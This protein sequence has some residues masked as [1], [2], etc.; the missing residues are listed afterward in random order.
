MMCTALM[1]LSS[2]LCQSGTTVSYVN[3]VMFFTDKADSSLGEAVLSEPWIIIN[4]HAHPYPN[5]RICGGTL[6]GASE[7]KKKS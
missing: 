6:V 5:L 7:N 4:H 3:V 1:V 2:A